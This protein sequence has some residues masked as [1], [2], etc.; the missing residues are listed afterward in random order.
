MEWELK[1]K[2]AYLNNGWE[3]IEFLHLFI[4]NESL[5][6]IH[7]SFLAYQLFKYLAFINNKDKKDI[8]FFD[9]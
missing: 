9:I 6:S 7:K 2:S 1:H 5:H 3:P 4:K 8:L